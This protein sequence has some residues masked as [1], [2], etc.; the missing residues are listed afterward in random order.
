MSKPYDVLIRGG[1]LVTASG[2]RRADVGIAGEK[3]IEIGEGL[4]GS[5]KDV[6]GGI[7]A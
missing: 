3:I 1:I 5:A 6:D 4:A 7:T 2:E